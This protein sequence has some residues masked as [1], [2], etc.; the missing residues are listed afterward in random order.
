[1]SSSKSIEVEIQQLETQLSPISS[2][3]DSKIREFAA[4]LPRNVAYWMRTET[5]H[6][7]EENA[8]KVTAAGVESLRQ[9]KS[10]LA[11]LISQLP[12][13][14][15]KAIGNESQ[16]PH[17]R[18]PFGMRDSSVHVTDY[19]SYFYFSTVFCTSINHLG[20]LLHKYG[21]LNRGVGS[22]SAWRALGNNTFRYYCNKSG[23]D[24]QEYPAVVEFKDLMKEHESIAEKLEQKRAEL[25]KAKATELWNDA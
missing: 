3:L 10:D 7:I 21:L 4:A 16:W 6:R 13:L 18:A 25:I 23:F 22:R 14:C 17:H 2:K 8:E 9:L 24:G 19:E 15:V 11:G 12:E 20:V 1:M 5:K